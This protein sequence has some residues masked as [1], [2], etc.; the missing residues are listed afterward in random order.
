MMG[1]VE[2]SARYTPIL[3]L[4]PVLSYRPNVLFNVMRSLLYP[5]T[6]EELRAN[7]FS[8]AAIH[9]VLS[10]SVMA[11]AARWKATGHDALISDARFTN[12]EADLRDLE[13]SMMEVKEQMQVVERTMLA[14]WEGAAIQDSKQIAALQQ[15][16][17][18]LRKAQQAGANAE[19][20]LVNDASQRLADFAARCSQE[21]GHSQE[22]LQVE[23]YL[24]L[25]PCTELWALATQ[26]RE[27][28]IRNDQAREAL[29]REVAA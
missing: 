16:V 2:C 8:E 11:A 12:F 23:D 3:R 24:Q 22:L 15:D 28:V 17:L 26:Y 7:G 18:L 29:R 1:P 6:E 14:K 27:L 25:R 20:A 9:D 10:D 5:R 4:P 19:T 21:P 13:E